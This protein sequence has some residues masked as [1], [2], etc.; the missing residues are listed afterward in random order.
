[1]LQQPR[2][3]LAALGVMF[4]ASLSLTAQVATSRL[5]GTV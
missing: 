1:M 4:I 2:Y 3:I 5:G